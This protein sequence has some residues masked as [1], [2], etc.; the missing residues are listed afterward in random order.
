MDVYSAADDSN[1]R[2]QNVYK[3]HGFAKAVLILAC[4]AKKEAEEEVFNATTS[5][6]DATT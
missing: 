6:E 5:K 3:N 1:Y 4:D 2:R